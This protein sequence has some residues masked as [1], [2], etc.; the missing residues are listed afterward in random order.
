MGAAMW[1]PMR[2]GLGAESVKA[3]A[4]AAGAG[5]DLFSWRRDGNRGQRA[6][7]PRVAARGCCDALPSTDKSGPQNGPS[8]AAG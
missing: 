3:G 7:R 1:G 2:R 6:A 4:R 8:L 5:L